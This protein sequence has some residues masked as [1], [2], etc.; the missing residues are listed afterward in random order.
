MSDLRFAR[1]V[2]LVGGATLSFTAAI[3]MVESFN[4]RML[5]DP[6]LTMGLLVIVGWLPFEAIRRFISPVEVTGTTMLLVAG[7][8]LIVNV[9]AFAVL[10]SGDRE[11]LNIRGAALH[12]AGD[13]LG[14]VAAIV[15]APP[16]SGIFQMSPRVEET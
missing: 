6:I 15:A 13:L 1:R 12:V 2:G 4:D 7:A 5:I 16:A 10:H 8:G 9:V 11:N 3:G 14:S